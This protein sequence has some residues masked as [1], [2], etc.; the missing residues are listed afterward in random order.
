VR[1]CDQHEREDSYG[2]RSRD[3]VVD[4]RSWTAAH[5]SAR[6]GATHLDCK[7]PI[8]SFDAL[9]PPHGSASIVNFRGPGGITPL[10]VASMQSTDSCH[11]PLMDG[12]STQF[13]TAT[14]VSDLIAND[15]STDDRTDF[16]GTF[17]HIFINKAV[18]DGRQHPLCTSRDPCKNG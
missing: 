5:F 10:M 17:Y 18:V 11:Y 14:V 6:N 12:R 7:V 4:Q 1:L 2:G 15:A 13:K 16:S 9:T 3:E 8:P